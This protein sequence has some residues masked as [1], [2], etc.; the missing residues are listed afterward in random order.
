MNSFTHLLRDERGSI[1]LS[2]AHGIE[3][4]PRH[5]DDATG[6]GKSAEAAPFSSYP[7]LEA[8]GTPAA[9]DRGP[10]SATT[11]L[12]IFVPRLSS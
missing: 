4:V 2:G 7:K 12:R 11:P 1:G 8:E 6:A 9:A 10:E 3:S 5:M